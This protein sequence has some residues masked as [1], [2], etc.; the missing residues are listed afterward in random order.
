MGLKPTTSSLG[1]RPVYGPTSES[2][3]ELEARMSRTPRY[4]TVSSVWKTD[5]VGP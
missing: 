1:G 3:T 4:K 2:T 5:L